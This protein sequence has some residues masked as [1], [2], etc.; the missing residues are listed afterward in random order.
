MQRIRRLLKNNG[1]WFSLLFAL[2]LALKALVP[3]GYMIST[4]SKTI[5]VMICNGSEGAKQTIAIPMNTET[6]SHHKE[7]DK[8]S[9]ACASGS[10]SKSTMTMTDPIQLVLALAFILLAGRMVSITIPSA[11]VIRWRPPLRGP[12]AFD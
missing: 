2:A 6:G 12:P 9:E 7:S 3:S 10:F 1:W 8:S 5:T 11:R 4:D